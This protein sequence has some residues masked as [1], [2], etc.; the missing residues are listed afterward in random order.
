MRPTPA[1]GSRTI[2]YLMDV[3]ECYRLLEL[4]IGAS[5]AA[6]EAAYLE[7]MERWRPERVP[8]SAGPDGL[9]HARHMVEKLNEALRTLETITPHPDSQ[10]A[11][12][13][14][15][16]RTSAKPKISALAAADIAAA[17][18]PPKPPASVPFPAT[19]STAA[20]APAVTPAPPPKPKPPISNSAPTPKP[21]EIVRSTPP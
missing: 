19:A 9:A 20:T 14:P 8:P 15:A 21:V 4:D 3:K 5:R 13:P 11:T 10:A 12:P 17:A 6:I 1:N 7:K 2:Q 18:P 16:A